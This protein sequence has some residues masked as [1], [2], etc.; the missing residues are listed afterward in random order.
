M[1]AIVDW[2]S[3]AG[4]G[5]V[6]VRYQQPPLV[7][8]CYMRRSPLLATLL[9]ASFALQLL[10]ASGGAACVLPGHEAHS[11]AMAAM[12]MAE[13]AMPGMDM[14]AMDMG[15]RSEPRT[16]APADAADHVP[17]DQPTTAAGCL[18][19]GPCAVAFIA[20][21]STAVAGDTRLPTHVISALVLEP[22]SSVF[23]PEIPPPRA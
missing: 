6:K 15:T 3:L 12:A 11:D 18:V 8:P 5:I 2:N 4:S 13:S 20:V 14:A 21:A 19:M 22:A 9:S 16:G 10:L 7:R 23:P 17:C 1:F